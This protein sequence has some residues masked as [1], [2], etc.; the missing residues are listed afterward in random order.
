[1]NMSNSSGS[2]NI[3]NKIVITR[4]AQSCNNAT[5]GQFLLCRDVEPS[6][7]TKG[8]LNSFLVRRNKKSIFDSN[9]VCVSVLVRTWCTATCLYY[10]EG[11]PLS[12]FVSPHIKERLNMM[13]NSFS[14]IARNIASYV[15]FMNHIT[16]KKYIKPIS[17]DSITIICPAGERR[18]GVIRV[19]FDEKKARWVNKTEPST[20]FYINKL[21]IQTDEYTYKKGNLFNFMK[22]LKSNNKFRNMVTSKKSG[23]VYVVTHSKTMKHM[24]K[25]FNGVLD[26]ITKYNLWTMIY[27]EFSGNIVETIRADKVLGEENASKKISKVCIL[28][29]PD[30]KSSELCGKKFTALV[31]KKL[32]SYLK[33][34]GP[35][36]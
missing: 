25:Y 27:D 35:K 5:C 28:R 34:K 3:N 15:I 12:L 4:H 20:I 11:V 22:F 14:N 7:T 9:K 10:K 23:N 16:Q 32:K 24:Y 31:N 13:G 1:M 18:P 29:N 19:D 6:I 17:N 30:C 8:I 2:E 33:S 26:D 21:L 36:K